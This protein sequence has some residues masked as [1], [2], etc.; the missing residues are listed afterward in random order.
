MTAAEP[1]EAEAPQVTAGISLRGL[2]KTFGS[3]VAVD[4][5]DLD[6]AD[7]EFFA[8]PQQQVTKLQIAILAR[9]LRVAYAPEA[10]H[11]HPA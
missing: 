11:S 3:V 4:G 1:T 5:I 2:R 8:V 9:R 10:F 6:V 7:G